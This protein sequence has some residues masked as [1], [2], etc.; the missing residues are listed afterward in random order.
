MHLRI[1]EIVTV[2]PPR[3]HEDLL[4]IFTNIDAAIPL[5][6]IDTTRVQVRF[7]HLDRN[8]GQFG[9]ATNEHLGSVG[10]EIIIQHPAG[11]FFG[12][13]LLIIDRQ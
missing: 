10:R 12:T 11:N 2:H 6:K 1:I 8:N 7:A 5:T 3:I 13:R 4:P 9:R